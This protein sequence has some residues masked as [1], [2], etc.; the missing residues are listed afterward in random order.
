MAVQ[1]TK[2]GREDL[3][4]DPALTFAQLLTNLVL[5]SLVL[6]AGFRRNLQPK[7]R[8]ILSTA[9]GIAGGITAHLRTIL[10]TEWS[11]LYLVVTDCHQYCSVCSLGST[12][13]S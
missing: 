9:G 11:N 1:T 4:R 2:S 8:H 5:R 12:C 7:T 13:P 6:E 3:N 10:R